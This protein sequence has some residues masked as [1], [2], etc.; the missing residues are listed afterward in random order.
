MLTSRRAVM[1]HRLAG[2]GGER[3]A[4]NFHWAALLLLPS[5]VEYV[6]VHE[7]VHLRE[8]HHTPEFWRRVERAMPDFE[9]R[10]RW[11]AAHCAEYVRL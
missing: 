6:V 10:K 1:Q 8:P 2:H 5:I 9:S 7:L 3:A 4:P 11:L